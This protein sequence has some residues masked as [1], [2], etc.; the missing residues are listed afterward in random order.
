MQYWKAN[1]AN[2]LL[3]ICH[4]VRVVGI[5]DHIME[6][7]RWSGLSALLQAGVT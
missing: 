7:Q 3:M 2:E 1:K 5:K 6:V 4:R